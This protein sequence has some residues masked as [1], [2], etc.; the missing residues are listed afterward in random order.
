[1]TRPQRLKFKSLYLWHRYTGLTCA[2]LVLVL[3]ATGLLLQH[4]KQLAL[5][6][7]F[8]VNR[9][10][11]EHYGVT[12]NPVTSYKTHAHW[13]SHAGE[14]LYLDGKS[15][16]GEYDNILGAA[17]TTFGYAVVSG[18]RLVLFDK[19][20]QL[21]ETLAADASLPEPALGIGSSPT[22]SVVM[23][24]SKTY[25]VPDDDF[26]TWTAY[27]GA[28][29]VWV[30]PEQT[31]AELLT[32]IQTYDVSHT[33]SMERLLLDLHSGRLLGKY[34]FI[35]MDLAAI[36]LLLLS[37]SGICVWLQRRKKDRSHHSRLE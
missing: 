25:W 18:Q 15:L 20:G 2:I 37:I 29:P 27:R 17:E 7:S 31:P 26:L 10:L 1:M 30:N 19:D 36:G 21:I 9:I 6:E 32:A 34:G 13:L 14:H 8:L 4:S 35:V 28:H 33:I 3:A 5:D 11:L 24:G 16:P 23:R 22:A 12:P